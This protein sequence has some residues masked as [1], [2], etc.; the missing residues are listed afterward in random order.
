M[1]YLE[2]YIVFGCILYIV[3]CI[4]YTF[5]YVVYC[6]LYF[7]SFSCILYIVYCILF[8]IC[9]V[10]YI[11][12]YIQNVIWG[13]EAPENWGSMREVMGGNGPSG[14]W[15]GMDSLSWPSPAG[16]ILNLLLFQ[17]KDHFF[18]YCTFGIVWNKN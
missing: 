18:K 16:G 5:D 11:R 9:S 12:V 15:E 13:G 4:L 3:Y 14:E 6:I 17:W 7:F 2:R 8:I 10:V 1:I